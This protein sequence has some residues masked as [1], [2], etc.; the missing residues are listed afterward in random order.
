MVEYVKNWRALAFAAIPA[1]VTV[2][3]I[4]FEYS[5]RSAAVIVG[6]TILLITVILSAKIQ[7]LGRAVTV[8]LQARDHEIAALRAHPSLIDGSSVAEAAHRA[9]D[10]VQ[11]LRRELELALKDSA[12]LKSTADLFSLLEA[13][14]S[15]IKRLESI[16]ERTRS[17]KDASTG[18]SRKGEARELDPPA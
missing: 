5:L 15:E 12:G 16:V 7:Q 3:A 14:Q 13:Q 17:G 11:D 6:L 8:A 1:D 9:N 10:S 2:A 18:R 4:L